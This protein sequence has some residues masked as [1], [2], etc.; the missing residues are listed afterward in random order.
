ML[1]RHEPKATC[2]AIGVRDLLHAGLMTTVLFLESGIVG[3][4]PLIQP[5]IYF[6]V[7]K[8][9]GCGKSRKSPKP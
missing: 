5:M 1:L 6:Y 9:E 2:G 8:A 4:C 3:M 7:E